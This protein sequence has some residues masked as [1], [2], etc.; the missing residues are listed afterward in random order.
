MRDLITEEQ[1]ADREP[2]FRFRH[3]LIRDVAYGTL[4][5]GA[6]RRTARRRRH[7]ASSW[8]GP[9]IDE[10]VEIEAYHLEQAVALRRELD[11]RADPADVERAVAALATSGVR[12]MSRE[13]DL[14]AL[15]FA[16]R[17]L[18][19]DPE[20]G[21]QRLEAE[22]LRV[23]SFRRLG[24]LGQGQE[25]AVKLEHDAEALGRPDIQGTSPSHTGARQPGSAANWPTSQALEFCSSAPVSCWLEAGDELVPRAL[26]CP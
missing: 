6:P 10:F 5:K 7:V 21:E 8:A 24:E 25:L 11:G 15:G 9:R 13:D 14:T 2:S 18:A 12:A 3:I 16:E 20:A 17:A 22:W 4:P 26:C 23:E 1:S 19:M